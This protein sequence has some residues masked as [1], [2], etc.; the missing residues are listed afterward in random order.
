MS[1]REKLLEGLGRLRA[2]ELELRGLLA[3]DQDFGAPGAA[4][5]P[6]AAP[7]PRL[8]VCVDAGHGGS[9]PGAVAAD[10]LTEKVLVLEYAHELRLVLQARGHRV[11]MTRVADAFVPLANR[12]QLADREGADVLV[13]LHANSADSKL[14]NG[15][16]VIHDDTTRPGPAGGIALATAVFQAMSRVPGMADV[17]TAAEVFPDRSPPVGGRNLAVLSTQ[18]A[19]AILV[20]LG[21]LTNEDDL[22]ELKA[23]GA[24]AALCSAIA[25]GLETWAAAR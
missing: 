24:R 6:P 8:V 10:G 4:E 18:H 14:A 7:G 9:D 25:D 12:A 2:L 11:V 13:S 22:R 19:V 1:T 3:L 16:W 20:E 17:D 15:A 21:F 5:A 23:P